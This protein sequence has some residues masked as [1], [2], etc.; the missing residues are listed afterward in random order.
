MGQK[1]YRD[2]YIFSIDLA[3]LIGAEICQKDV[4]GSTER[5]IFIPMKLNGITNLKGTLHFK[6]QR[7]KLMNKKRMTHAIS[8]VYPNNVRKYQ[9]TYGF[10][11]I[12]ETEDIGAMRIEK[13]DFIE[14][15]ATSK[16]F[17]DEFYKALGYGTKQNE[18]DIIYGA[19]DF[20][21]E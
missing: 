11:D 14:Q 12:P 4:Y 1:K 16:S 21:V 17:D 7:V 10:D 19:E 15:V 18:N 3:K 2:V 5:G 6:A 8:V 9:R 13:E 20:E